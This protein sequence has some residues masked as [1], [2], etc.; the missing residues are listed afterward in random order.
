LTYPEI[1]EANPVKAFLGFERFAHQD[2]RNADGTAQIEDA[3]EALI[4]HTRLVPRELIG[5]GKQ[6]SQLRPLSQRTEDAVRTCVNAEAGQIIGYVFANCHPPWQPR[7][8]KLLCSINSQVL[9][10]TEMYSLAREHNPSEE[11]A[12]EDIKYLVSLGLLGYAE[13]DPKRHR[14]FYFQRFVFDEPYGHASSLRLQRDYFFIHPALKEWIRARHA[15]QVEWRHQVNLLVGDGLPFESS[16]PLLR[17]M[18][19][20]SFPSIL[21]GGETPL[22]G[23]GTGSSNQINFLFLALCAWKLRNGE[24]WPTMRDITKIASQLK[25][26]HPDIKF[27]SIKPDQNPEGSQVRVWARRLNKANELRSLQ[28]SFESSVADGDGSAHVG[29]VHKPKAPDRRRSGF[30]TISA[31][32]ESNA[33]A[34]FAFPKVHPLDVHISEEVLSAIAL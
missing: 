13:P 16:P 27:P 18:I 29:R 26:K 28:A 20:D 4:R 3:V 14:H 33:D 15:P 12:T 23:I 7:L 30:I 6:I 2:R 25:Q 17:L 10:G 1:V 11:A 5:I 9:S 19:R 34:S 24:T 8:E 22:Q 31:P 32:S 21:L